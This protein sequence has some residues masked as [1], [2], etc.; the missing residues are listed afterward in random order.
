M[1][2]MTTVDVAVQIRSSADRMKNKFVAALDPMCL[3][4]PLPL[5]L[6]FSDASEISPPKTKAKEKSIILKNIKLIRNVPFKKFFIIDFGFCF[7]KIFTVE[8]Y[9][10]NMLPK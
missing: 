3:T 1:K 9:F 5:S 4:L 7:E 10:I 8:I 2:P 6:S